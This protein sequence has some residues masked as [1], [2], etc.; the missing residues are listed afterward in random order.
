MMMD[1]VS[2]N[3]RF[4]RIVALGLG[5]LEH[6]PDSKKRGGLI[7]IPKHLFPVRGE[8]RIFLGGFPGH[9]MV[10]RTFSS[11]PTTSLQR[12]GSER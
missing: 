11:T 1:V 10:Y 12:C 2:S 4:G 7:N 8:S 6:V 5:L 9:P 3:R